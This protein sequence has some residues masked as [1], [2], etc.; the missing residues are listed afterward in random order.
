[1]GGHGVWAAGWKTGL[2][3]RAK[4]VRNQIF[5]KNGFIS[6]NARNYNIITT[7]V[8]YINATLPR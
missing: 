6:L 7:R 1:M 2:Q 3:R 8:D 4:S 5:N